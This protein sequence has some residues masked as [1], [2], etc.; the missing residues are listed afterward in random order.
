MDR[1]GEILS[2]G[3]TELIERD[4]LEKKLRGKEKL[5]V[6]YGIDPTGNKIHIGHAIPFWK[7]KEFQDLGHKIVLILG[8]FTARIGDPSDKM[9]ERKPLSEEEVKDN[10]ETY[11]DQ[12][13]K[14]LDLKK[15]EIR[16][17]SDWHDKST[18]S[19]LITEAMN[20][21]V[22]QMIQRDNFAERF[23]LSKPIGLH[24]F[25]YPLLQGYDSVV[26]KADLEIGGNDQYFNLL[27]GRTLQKKFGQKAQDIMTLSLLTGDDGRKMSKSYN[28]C[29]FIDDPADQMYGKAM[30]IDDKLISQYLLL[31]TDIS[32]DKIK[33]IEKDLRSGANPRNAKRELAREIVKRYYGEKTALIAEE[34]F[35]RTFV[36]KELPSEI[37]EALIIDKNWPL[38]DLLEYLGLT[39]SKSEARR[40]IDQG[41]I[42][43][44]GAVIG[45]REATIKP[46]DGV[47]IQVGK[48]KF[49]RLKIDK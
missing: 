28:N 44:D 48:R 6:K 13:S 3:V 34:T 25:L 30:A 19:D 29:I 36:R 37:D 33:K 46:K 1:I 21:T 24:E 4:N 38:A 23:R 5:R 49:K 12:I 14:I 32:T 20:F 26:V 27:A 40:L 10:M 15:T 31:A 41:G 9:A 17:N 7:L 2:R 42:K 47:I 35:D 8:D 22:N 43:I 39:K 16:H 18:K 11:L 45:D